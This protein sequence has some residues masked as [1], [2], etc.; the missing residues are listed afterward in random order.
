MDIWCCAFIINVLWSKKKMCY[1]IFL[2][3]CYKKQWIRHDWQVHFIIYTFLHTSPQWFTH[4]VSLRNPQF[5]RQWRLNC[6]LWFVFSV[7]CKWKHIICNF[8]KGIYYCIHNVLSIVF[9]V[10]DF[11]NLKFTVLLWLF[12]H[13]DK[14]LSLYGWAWIP[15]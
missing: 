7:R 8:Y 1:F 4:F 15:L 10:S 3:H 12:C 11:I 14:A 13:S 9:I 5:T 2:T 6:L